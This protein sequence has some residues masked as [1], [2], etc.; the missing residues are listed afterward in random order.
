LRTV[1]A[2]IAEEPVVYANRCTEY[3]P[4]GP[5]RCMKDPGHEGPHMAFNGDCPIH[6]DGQ[7]Q[8]AE[9]YG[10]TR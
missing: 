3:Q 2:V 5:R 8:W 7:H 1:A 6:W 10:Q 9:T 4:A